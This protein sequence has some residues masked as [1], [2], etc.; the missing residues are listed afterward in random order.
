[1]SSGCKVRIRFLLE[2]DFSGAWS[3]IGEIISLKDIT[4][5]LKTW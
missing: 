2:F 1:M 4:S 5:Y 3:V